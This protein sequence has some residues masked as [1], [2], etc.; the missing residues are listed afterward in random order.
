MNTT[1]DREAWRVL[2]DRSGRAFARLDCGHAMI[3]GVQG[4][5]YPCGACALRAAGVDPGWTLADTLICDLE[6]AFLS[7]DD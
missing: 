7:R 3:G 6:E 4:E 2:R 5:R 1:F